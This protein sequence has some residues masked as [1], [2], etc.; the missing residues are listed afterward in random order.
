MN[1][2]AIFYEEGKGGEN[3][4]KKKVPLFGKSRGEEAGEVQGNRLVSTI[5]LYLLLTYLNSTSIID[6]FLSYSLLEKM[7]WQ[8]SDLIVCEFHWKRLINKDE[9]DGR[10]CMFI[11]CLTSMHLNLETLFKTR[12]LVLRTATSSHLQLR[13]R[14]LGKFWC[15]IE[16]FSLYHVRYCGIRTPSRPPPFILNW[17]LAEFFSHITDCHSC[18]RKFAVSFPLPSYCLLKFTFLKNKSLAFMFCRKITICFCLF[19]TPWAR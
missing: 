18:H 17:S 13:F 6:I 10:T 12:M 8:L 9:F 11:V 2:V 19:Y 7:D 4:R 3:Y 14:Y 1:C 15:G 16:V 5:L